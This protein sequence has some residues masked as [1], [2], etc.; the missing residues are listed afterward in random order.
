LLETF[1]SVLGLSKSTAV[2]VEMSL[3]A[4]AD[5]DCRTTGCRL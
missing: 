4:I 5:Q 1:S 3:V 2:T